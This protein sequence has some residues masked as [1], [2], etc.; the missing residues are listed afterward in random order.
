MSQARV[1]GLN[2]YYQLLGSGEPLVLVHGSW[3]DHTSWQLVARTLAESFRVLTYDRRGHSQSEGAAGQG[4][5]VQ[6]EDDLA[7]LIQTLDLGPA[8]IAGNSYGASVVLGLATR[9][10]ELFRSVIVHEPPL[11]GIVAGDA[12]LQPLMKEMQKK[13]DAVVAQLEAGD[14]AGGTRRFVEEV[15]FGPG[16]WDQLPE[17]ARQTFMGNALTFVD[18]QRD[19]ARADLDLAK[20]SS[21]SAPALLTQ[22]DQSP[23]WFPV[24]MKKLSEALEQAEQLTLSGAGH[25]PHR[26]HPSLYVETLTRFIAER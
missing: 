18:E 25:A 24:I 21:F 2:L 8:H 9:H 16:A 23:P 10:P 4:S 22:G 20:L 26:T 14:L 12:E 1:N 11:T 15:S 17:Q 7:A 5:R 13:V 19:P 3:G 6:D